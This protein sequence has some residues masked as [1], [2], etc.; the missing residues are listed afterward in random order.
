MTNLMFLILFT[1]AC[2][3]LFMLVCVL[4]LLSLWWHERSHHRQK[5][6]HMRDWK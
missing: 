5:P 2:A 6:Y 3:V 4:E 1:I